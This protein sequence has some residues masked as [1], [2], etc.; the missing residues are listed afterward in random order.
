MVWSD[1]FSRRRVLGVL[2]GAL[3]PFGLTGRGF[4][5]PS[6]S[7]ELYLEK[8]LADLQLSFAPAR[9]DLAEFEAR[10]RSG[11][12]IEMRA[13]VELHWPPGFRRRPFQIKAQDPGLAL[14]LLML[15]IEDYFTSL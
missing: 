4:A 3:L 13:I 5:A 11:G 10:S 14:T 9:L 1:R 7:Y 12:H 15:A 8:F 2:G 6:Q